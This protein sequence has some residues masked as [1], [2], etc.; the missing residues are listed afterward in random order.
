MWYIS[1]IN[2]LKYW[3]YATPKHYVEMQVT[4][5]KKYHVRKIYFVVIAIANNIY[6]SVHFSPRK[7]ACVGVK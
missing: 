2:S 4:Y 5:T 6:E 7:C 1:C 3:F